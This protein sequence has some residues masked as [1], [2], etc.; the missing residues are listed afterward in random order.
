VRNTSYMT[1]C[2]KPAQ[3]GYTI[4]DVWFGEPR[5]RRSQRIA[6]AGDVLQDANGDLFVLEG[7]Q[8]EEVFVSPLTDS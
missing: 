7:S 1:I 5:V 3:Y 4:M 6:L 2:Y 8:G